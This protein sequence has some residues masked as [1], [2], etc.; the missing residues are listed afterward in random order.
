MDLQ[1]QVVWIV[2]ASKGIGAALARE[3]QARG[4]QV[5]VTARS[6][7]ELD[8][9]AGG[10]MLVAPADVTDPAA[11]DAALDTVTRRL[12]PPDVLVVT[13]AE[14]RAMSLDDWD[15]Q[16]FAQ[17][18]DVG[19]VGA[20]NAIGAVLP[21]MLARGHG[22]I[23]GFIAPAAYRGLPTAEAYGAAKAG[24]RNLLQG[25]Q[26]QAGQRGLRVTIIAP[27]SVRTPSAQSLVPHLPMGVDPD[28]AARAVCDGLE[29]ERPEIAFP[30]RLA[31]PLKLVQVAPRWLWPRLAGRAARR[32]H[33]GAAARRSR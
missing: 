4:A 10:A 16:A 3:M 23:A 21:A 14:A 33:E 9:V 29:R 7:D 27:A 1:H 25:L 31:R 26:A 17:V 32:S 30:G 24:L 18:I 6:T 22:T 5:A 12:G 20:S 13:A 19:L 15:R 11:L 2:G 8:R 28:T